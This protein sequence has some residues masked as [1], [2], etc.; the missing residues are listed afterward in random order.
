MEVV[1]HS[2][3]LWLFG[4]AVV[5]GVPAIRLRAIRDRVARWGELVRASARRRFAT[6]LR[7]R[8]VRRAE[9]QL[10]EL[11]LLV[12]N[13][14]RAGR[15]MP[16]ALQAAAAQLPPPLGEEVACVVGDLR[17][18]RSVEEALD[19]LR[20][21]L[22]GE[23]IAL[24]VWTIA[25]LR[26]SGGNLVEAFTMLRETIEGRRRIADRIRVLTSQGIFQG[27]VL[28]LLP[29]ALGALLLLIAPEF[30]AP[31]LRTRLGNAF[32]VAAVLLE[33]IGALWLRRIVVIRV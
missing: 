16:Q 20:V 3:V 31:L 14:L 11:L 26:R 19:D 12:G 8:H 33:A 32:L 2:A 4:C 17:L 13:A 1:L 28:L 27:A 30:V 9:E 21:R 24:F 15:A 25:A 23:E 6:L 5:I 22:P 7:R 10:P 29:W 18:G